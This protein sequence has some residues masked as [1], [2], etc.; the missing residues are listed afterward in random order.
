MITIMTSS[1]ACRP[2]LP[3]NGIVTPVKKGMITLRS[4]Y[5]LIP[6]YYVVFKIVQLFHGF[7][8]LIAIVFLKA[9]NVSIDINKT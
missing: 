6:V 3:E 9:R 8:A 5:V 1:R 4:I 7:L 2:F